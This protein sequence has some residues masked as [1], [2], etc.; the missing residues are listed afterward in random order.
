VALKASHMA[1]FFDE[2]R[3]ERGFFRKFDIAF[4]TNATDG[5]IVGFA[6]FLCI[7]Y[8]IVF[9]F[10]LCTLELVFC[11]MVLMILEAVGGTVANFAFSSSL[12]LVEEVFR[13]KFVIAAFTLVQLDIQMDCLDVL[14]N[15]EF[16]VKGFVAE[17]TNV[18]L[19][20]KMHC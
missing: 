14:T 20:L 1:M 2:M 8:R 5:L 11:F 12:M 9:I 17:I 3:V 15:I 18:I 19:L 16:S 6:M 10:T 13:I 4:L 7:G